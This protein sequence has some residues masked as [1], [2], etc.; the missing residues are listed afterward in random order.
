LPVEGDQVK[1]IE[2]SE[3]ADQIEACIAQLSPQ[4]QDVI[5]LRRFD[6]SV[7]DIAESTGLSRVNVSQI[8]RRARIKL[9]ECM[10]VEL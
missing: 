8:S 4:E 5:N 9:C 10:D 6:M 3:A 7:E 2:E 1:S